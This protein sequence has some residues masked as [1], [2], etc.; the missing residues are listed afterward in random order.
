MFVEGRPGFTSGD[1]AEDGEI[2]ASRRPRRLRFETLVERDGTSGNISDVRGTG[3]GN[4]DLEEHDFAVA[5]SRYRNGYE[6]DIRDPPEKDGLTSTGAAREEYGALETAM[7]ESAVEASACRE[8]EEVKDEEEVDE[9]EEAEEDEED[10]E[11][12]LLPPLQSSTQDLDSQVEHGQSTGEINRG[13]DHGAWLSW[14]RERHRFVQSSKHPRKSRGGDWLERLPSLGIEDDDGEENASDRDDL[15]GVDERGLVRLFD[16][17]F[18]GNDE[19]SQGSRT[20]EDS[21]EVCVQDQKSGSD[22]VGPGSIGGAHAEDGISRCSMDESFVPWGGSP[23]AISKTNASDATGKK[24]HVGVTV[25]R[26]PSPRFSFLDATGE[27]DPCRRDDTAPHDPTPHDAAGVHE[28]T[29]SSSA[30]PAESARREPEDP[31]VSVRMSEPSPSGAE[32]QEDLAPSRGHRGGEDDRLE[33]EHS[34]SDVAEDDALE[35]CESDPP[36]SKP[37]GESP[38]PDGYPSA[39]S[40]VELNPGRADTDF[41]SNGTIHGR[42]SY[43]AAASGESR[44]ED[45]SPDVVL[46][47]SHCNLSLSEGDG[48]QD[49]GGYAD[50]SET[51]GQHESHSG[52]EEVRVAPGVECFRPSEARAGKKRQRQEMSGDHSQGSD[53]EPSAEDPDE[54]RESFVLRREA[55]PVASRAAGVARGTGEGAEESSCEPRDNE[56]QGMVR[57]PMEGEVPCEARESSDRATASLARRDEGDGLPCLRA[58]DSPDDDVAEEGLLDYSGSGSDA[59]NV[60]PRGFVFR[61]VGDPTLAYELDVVGQDRFPPYGGRPESSA[62]RTRGGEP[63]DVSSTEACDRCGDVMRDTCNRPLTLVRVDASLCKVCVGLG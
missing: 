56:V 54:T 33:P 61:P 34:A 50:L 46:S 17:A 47:E 55:L 26:P 48:V 11:E 52:E 37:R 8:V 42:P 18:P 31:V 53:V 44:Q 20:P 58:E 35:N 40:G 32:P 22:C 3:R 7:S 38:A 51:S 10:E 15:E 1:S 36:R 13:K 25:R 16:Y 45:P 63:L 30:Y 27:V 12:E 39:L 5:D 6:T 4:K 2:R 43:D 21:M 28:E 29:E 41:G 24:T 59:E 57:S 49:S 9:E 23:S 62:D 60:G 19:A 14:R